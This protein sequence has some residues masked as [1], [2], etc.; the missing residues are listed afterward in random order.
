MLVMMVPLRGQWVDVRSPAPR[1][2]PGRRWHYKY[3]L[4]VE[5]IPWVRPVP[6]VGVVGVVIAFLHLI[7][8]E[9]A[10]ARLVGPGRMLAA[11]DVV[12]AHL[13]FVEG[14]GLHATTSAPAPG[15]IPAPWSSA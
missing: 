2:P 15:R 1:L 11:L 7:P 6:D 13:P 10:D 8:G 9:G 12:A 5:V 3:F 14:P 4:R